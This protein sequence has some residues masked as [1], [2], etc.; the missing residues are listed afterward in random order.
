VHKLRPRAE[1]LFT[2]GLAFIVEEVVQ[3][4][5]GKVPVDYRVPE[6]LDGGLHVVRPP[7]T[8]RTA[9]SCC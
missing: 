5:W 6:E 8:R 4:I 1:L 7:P 3:M 2:F 9:C